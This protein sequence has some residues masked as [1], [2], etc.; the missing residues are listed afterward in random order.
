[1]VNVEEWYNPYTVWRLAF[2]LDLRAHNKQ[3]S[4]NL[5]RNTKLQVYT[6]CNE[7][8]EMSPHKE[9]T[10][11]TGRLFFQKSLYYDWNNWGNSFLSPPL[12]IIY[13]YGCL[14]VRDI[15]NLSS[16]KS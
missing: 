12:A 9:K 3:A 16:P 15:D 11:I 14:Y 6:V 4:L 10:Y 5:I 8:A 2:V 1:M 13:C 7:L